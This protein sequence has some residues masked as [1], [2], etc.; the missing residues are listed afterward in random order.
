M[1]VETQNNRAE[2]QKPNY[3]SVIHFPSKIMIASAGK[4]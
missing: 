2:V 4:K 3:D 1:E